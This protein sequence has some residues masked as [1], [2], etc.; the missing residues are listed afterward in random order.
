MKDFIELHVRLQNLTAELDGDLWRRMMAETAPP[1]KFPEEQAALDMIFRDAKAVG[2]YVPDL[3]AL[4]RRRPA[5]ELERADRQAL[6]GI[7]GLI[8]LLIRLLLMILLLPRYHDHE[9]L[10][11][12]FN[13]Y[14][15]TLTLVE[16]YLAPGGRR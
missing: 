15:Q 5:E 7:L 2:G 12:T 10:I 8:Q 11:N 13:A 14:R 9:D 1:R 16:D 6:T 3:M 4:M